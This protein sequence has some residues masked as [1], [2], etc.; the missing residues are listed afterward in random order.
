MTE[1]DS[2]II[3]LDNPE[4][5]VLDNLAK[6]KGLAEAKLIHQRLRRYT[7]VMTKALNAEKELYYSDFI[8]INDHWDRTIFHKHLQ[9]GNDLGERIAN[10]FATAFSQ[11]QQKVVVIFSDFVELESYMIKEAFDVLENED[12]VLGPAREGGYYL[13]GMKKFFPMLFE[14]KDWKSTNIL[15]DTLIDL[16]KVNARYYLLKT[17]CDFSSLQD[18]ELLEKLTHEKPKDW[19]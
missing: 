16:K 12:V 17:L 6:M 7:F 9:I 1:K 19:F 2:L 18:F 13:I 14:G 4:K 3:F 11:G 10:A 8:P 15:I 5:I